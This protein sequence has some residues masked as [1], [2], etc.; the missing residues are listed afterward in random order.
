M[1]KRECVVCGEEYEPK[2][3]NQKYCSQKCADWN[4]ID[5]AYFNVFY[6]DGFRCRYCG[7]TPADGITLTIDHVY[8]QSKGGG[9]EKI[10]LVTSCKKCNSHKLDVSMAEER[11]KEIWWQNRKLSEKIPRKGYE[12]MREEFEEEYP[13]KPIPVSLALEN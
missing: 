1:E 9:D 10:N 4:K 7:K 11:I 5:P 13:E 8:P 12:E 3:K 6:R 2:A